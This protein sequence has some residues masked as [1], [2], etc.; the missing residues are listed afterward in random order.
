MKKVKLSIKSVFALGVL[1]LTHTAFSQNKTDEK[2]AK[3]DKIDRTVIPLAEP[4]F[5]GVIGKTYKES[6]AEWPKLPAPPESQINLK[7]I[8]NK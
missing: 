5:G 4:K 7:R 2:K 6:E 3:T 1:L 8:N